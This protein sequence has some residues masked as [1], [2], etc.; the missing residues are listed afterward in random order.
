MKNLK[1]C[2]ICLCAVFVSSLQAQT[3][4]ISSKDAIIAVSELVVKTPDDMDNSDMEN[5]GEIIADTFS[6][7]IS[8]LR[9]R[10]VKIVTRTKYDAMQ[11]EG[12][13]TTTYRYDPESIPAS[14]KLLAATHLLTAKINILSS[15]NA[16]FTAQIIEIETGIITASINS[17]SVS[18]EDYEDIFNMI[19]E[20]SGDLMYNFSEHR[21]N[22]Y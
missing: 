16:W 21:K 9:T 2:V 8:N 4:I 11:K 18:F 10:G 1:L 7:L 15:K 19:S 13:T 12:T 22:P 14:G 20:F 3:P 17:G 5:A 6:G